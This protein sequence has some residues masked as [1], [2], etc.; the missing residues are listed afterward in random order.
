MLWWL[1]L[2]IFHEAGTYGRSSEGTSADW[3]SHES[4]GIHEERILV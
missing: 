2:Q 3:P 4:K 1:S